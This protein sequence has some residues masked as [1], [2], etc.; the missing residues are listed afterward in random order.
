MRRHFIFVLMY[1]L[2]AGLAPQAWAFETPLPLVQNLTQDADAAQRQGMPL[3]LLV[4][5][6]GCPFCEEVRKL[7]LAPLAGTGVIVRQIHLDRD[8]D[9]IDFEGKRT[10]QR[11]F[12]KTLALRVAPTVFFFDR[13]GRQIAEPIVGAIHEDFY[14]EYLDEAIAAAK[15]KLALTGQSASR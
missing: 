4:S 2:C 10:T 1:C 14:Q 15:K 8:T 13:T 11:R 3:I 9:L 6:T 5:L 7:H 12:V